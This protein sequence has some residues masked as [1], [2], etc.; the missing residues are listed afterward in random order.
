MAFEI[1]FYERENKQVPVKEFLKS[2]PV[3]HAAKASRSIDLLEKFGTNL[4]KPYVIAMKGKYKGLWELRVKFASDISRIF[5]FMP[6]GDTFVLLH[7]FVKKTDETPPG[8]L[9]IAKRYMDDYREDD[10]NG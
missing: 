1:K 4:T 3:K 2:L 8:E 5:Y 6:V 10:Q 9:E 7:G